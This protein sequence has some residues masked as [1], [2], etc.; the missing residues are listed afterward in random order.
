MRALTVVQAALDHAPDDSDDTDTDD[1]ND[2]DDLT[3]DLD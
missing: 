1:T 2:T 3:E